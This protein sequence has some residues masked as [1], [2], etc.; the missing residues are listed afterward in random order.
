MLLILVTAAVFQL[1]ISWLKLVASPSIVPIF[2][3]EE[4]IQEP[5][6]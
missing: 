2:V 4:V 1:P 5:M 3:T 6:F